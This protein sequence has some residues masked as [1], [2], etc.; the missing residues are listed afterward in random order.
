M[1][2]Q[3]NYK[4]RILFL[5]IIWPF[6]AFI[7]SIYNYRKNFSK[8]IFVGFSILFGA[9][10]VVQDI[11]TGAD[12][13]KIFQFFRRV[14]SLNNQDALIFLSSNTK[15]LFFKFSV[16]ILSRVTDNASALYAF[17]AFLYSL[18]FVLSISILI[19]CI[20]DKVKIESLV[21]LILF[22]VYIRFSAINGLRFWVGAFIYIYSVMKYIFNGE[23]KY[24]FLILLTPVVHFSFFFGVSIFGVYL[25]IQNNLYIS[26]IFYFIFSIFSFASIDFISQ[27]IN[28]LNETQSS[29]ALLYLN[30]YSQSIAAERREEANWFFKN[31]GII[32]RNFSIY[33]FIFPS[34]FLRK[35]GLD[36]IERRLFSFLLLF[37]SALN[38]VYKS[39]E[40]YRRFFEI[41][42]MIMLAFFFKL[43]I[44]NK[45]KVKIFPYIVAIFL[46][47]QIILGLRVGM[48][49]L[50]ANLLFSNIFYLPF[51]E[52][53]SV[54]DFLRGR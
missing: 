24:I 14:S 52:N 51:F 33:A 17:N 6:G 16:F 37:A 11:T 19:K 7:N 49:F 15:D 29:A 30:E 8:Y 12:S 22:A 36:I 34:L 4:S 44:E 26:F 28:F 27:N 46:L 40:L 54:I 35:V 21:F 1:I 3:Q 43:S 39:F 5:F 47:P 23:K 50:N 41:F 38:F 20:S 18:F 32:A 45:I 10:F 53:I 42:I 25:L 13:A 48:D 9:T 2:N 31:S